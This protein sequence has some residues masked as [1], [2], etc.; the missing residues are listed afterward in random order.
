MGINAIF[1]SRNWVA[2]P[3]HFWSVVFFVFGSMVGSFLNVCIHRMPIG[4]SIVRPPSHCP[5]CKYS[6]PWF[7]N[8]PLV[9]WLYLSGKCA[10]CG[11]PISIRYFLVELLTGLVF[12]SC[13]LFYGSQSAMLALVY[14]LFLAGLIAATFI[15]FEHFIIPDEITIGGIAVGIFCSFIVPAMHHTKSIP[16]SMKQSFVGALVGGGLIYGILRLGKLAFGRQKLELQ[17]D[18]KIL[19]TETSIILPGQELLYEDLFYR[20]SDVIKLVAAKVELTDR[21]YRDVNVRLTP[22]KLQIGEDVLATND[23]PYLEV[24]TNEVVLPREAMGLG[25]VK[26]MAAIGA[27]L[28]WQAVIFSLVVSSILGSIVGVSLIAFK[29]QAWSSRLPYGPYIA[30]A[31]AIWLFGGMHFVQWWVARYLH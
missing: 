24:V 25:D 20:D 15:D 2:V 29:K 18:T 1:D 3:F 30:L 26:F 6:I 12:L 5:H 22:V 27:F 7:L 4:E 31:A 23:V 19:F 14:C 28:G 9:T 13:W 10:N 8:I 21:C 17:A 11:A 16:D